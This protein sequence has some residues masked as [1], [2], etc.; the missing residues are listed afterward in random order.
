M[1]ECTQ[2]KIN[3]SSYFK[4]LSTIWKSVFWT[5]IALLRQCLQAFVDSEYTAYP[6]FKIAFAAPPYQRKVTVWNRNLL[7]IAF[8][9]LTGNIHTDFVTLRASSNRTN[10][11][12][13]RIMF[14]NLAQH[15]VLLSWLL[16]SGII[17]QF[18]LSRL[19]GG[20]DYD[21]TSIRRPFDCLSTV[22]N[23]TVT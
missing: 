5:N 22:I 23:V 4:K 11:F 15:F 18:S 21:S 14:S 9:T 3:V 10:Y 19:C 13:C 7:L 6:L 8:A 16:A 12:C 20:H 1:K 2:H 17:P